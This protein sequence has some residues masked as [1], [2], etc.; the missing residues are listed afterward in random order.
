MF[1]R[2]EVIFPDEQTVLAVPATA[3]LSA[4]Y[5]DSVYVI[6]SNGRRRTTSGRPPASLSAPA[7]RGVIS[8]AW[9]PV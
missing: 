1:V 9:K 2:V 7:G 4:P 6:E 8:S 5:G 3:I